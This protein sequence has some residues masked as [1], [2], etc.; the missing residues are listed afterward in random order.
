MFAPYSIGSKESAEGA[1]GE[2]S[3]DDCVSPS[4]VGL[5]DGGRRGDEGGI[6]G[7]ARG[8]G[9]DVWGDA[10]GPSDGALGLGVEEWGSG[11]SVGRVKIERVLS[12]GL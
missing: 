5:A 3:G 10:G 8:G 4:A 1:G 12:D 7:L 9:E 2:Q 6:E 11:G